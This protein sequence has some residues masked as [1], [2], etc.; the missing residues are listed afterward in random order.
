[1]L[2]ARAMTVG[3][4]LF[5]VGCAAAPS[6]E[7]EE[8]ME[9][10]A[11]EESVDPIIVM[12]GDDP[13]FFWLSST[14]QALRILAQAPLV[15][16]S[17]EMV[18]TPLLAS[19]N[20]QRLLGYLARCTL[21]AGESLYSTASAVSFDGAAGLAPQW[22]S[23][24]L[25]SPESQRWVTSCL[26]QTLNGLR[27]KVPIRLAGR[28]EA[29]NTPPTAAAASG[30]TIPD[31]T[32]F[33]NVFLPGGPA[34]FACADST[35]LNDCGVSWSADALARLCGVSVACGLTVLG[36]CRLSCDTDEF[37]NATCTDPTGTLYPEAISTSLEQTGFLSL[38][39][40][41][42]P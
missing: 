23:A 16:A 35:L 6:D 26:L 7:G 11:R 27:V 12:N 21:P 40:G 14:Q 38:Y 29:I 20:G 30:Y 33:G 32:M 34:A 2:S 36:P 37:G 13:T 18:S 4:C 42:S 17:G 3:L 15:A 24:P 5:F 9:V 31:A 25:A 39:P 1:M 28:H 22:A 10:E 19:A 8:V 41:C